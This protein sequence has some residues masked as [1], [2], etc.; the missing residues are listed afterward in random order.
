[1]SRTANVRPE[2]DIRRMIG[3]SFFFG[4]SRE[5]WTRRIWLALIVGIVL[6]LVVAF[7]MLPDMP[8]MGDGPAY[9]RQVQQVLSG[10]L[11]HW[12]F[13]PGTALVCL[14]VIS[15][16]GSGT[17]A[18]H[19]AGSLISIAFLLSVTWLA[20]SMRLSD[21]AVFMA[22]ALAAIYPHGVLSTVQISSLPLAAMAVS[23][24]VGSALRALR[25]PSVLLWGAAAFFCGVAVLTRPGTLLLAP[26]M[27][28]LAWVELRDNPQQ[29]RL[30]AVAVAAL[31]VVLS[32]MTLP[33][34]SFHAE[35]GHGWTLS[36][37]SEWNLLLANNRYTPDYKTGHFG[38][39]ALTDLDPEAESFIR[40]FFDG[41]TA[42][43]ASLTERTAMLDSART[44]M[45]EHPIR[46]LYRATNRIRGFFGCDYTAARELQ[47]VFGYSDVVFGI[48][49]LIEGGAFL[50]VLFGW[51]LYVMYRVGTG[52]GS[53]LLH[54]GVL[55]VIMAPHVVAFALAK[56]HLP[57]VPFLICATAAAFVTLAE[58]PLGAKMWLKERRKSLIILV[59]VVAAFQLEHLMHL[60]ILR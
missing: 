29:I 24:S 45:K 51:L 6:R 17:F 8:Q 52:A 9:V 11:D 19:V 57:V 35:R 7:V 55:G 53:R 60:I 3:G 42:E 34:M 37:N 1:M 41:E 39:R 4:R 30:V 58:K 36:T 26:F 15:S 5:V 47:L 25:T 18:E 56:Y 38:Q 46:T 54:L 44:F 31:S 13:P 10:T 32:A 40:G 50:L 43:S 48:V 49:M 28:V 21:P 14:P 33:V 2:S 12:Y 20:R 16:L 27:I 59:V 22:T 23:M